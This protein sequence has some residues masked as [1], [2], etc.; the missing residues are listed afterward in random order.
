[1]TFKQKKMLLKSKQFSNGFMNNL[2]DDDLHI[3]T[4]LSKIQIHFTRKCNLELLVS[5]WNSFIFA[6][7]PNE[8]D[9]HFKH[10]Q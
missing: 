9:L 1:M 6:G 4:I 3:S 7:Y 8:I 10:L 5:G 2:L